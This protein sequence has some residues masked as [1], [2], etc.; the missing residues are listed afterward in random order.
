MRKPYVILVSP[1]GKE[2]SQELTEEEFKEF[3]IK[4]RDL[5]QKPY[6]HSGVDRR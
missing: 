5:A 1:Q 6:S 4:I 3:V 2:L